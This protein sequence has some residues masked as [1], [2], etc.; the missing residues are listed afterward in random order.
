M[1]N[2]GLHYGK[3]IECNAIELDFDISCIEAY[4]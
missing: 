3:I 1:E 4:N 2:G